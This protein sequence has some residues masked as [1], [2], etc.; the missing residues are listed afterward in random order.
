MLSAID[1]WR[2]S[3]EKALREHIEHGIN[4]ASA[5]IAYARYIDVMRL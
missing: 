3:V 4:S 2:F 5:T 1:L